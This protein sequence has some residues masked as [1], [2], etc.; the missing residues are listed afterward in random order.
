MSA[1]GPTDPTRPVPPAGGEPAAGDPGAGE[2]TSAVRATT[3]VAEPPD[4]IPT[5]PPRSGGVSTGVAI[6]AALA[7]GLLGLVIGF[8]IFNGDGDDT[9][10]DATAALD[11]GTPDEPID[12]EPDEAGPAG[13]GT[14]DDTAGDDDGV[15]ADLEAER[16]GLEAE[17]DELAQQVQDLEGQVDDLQ[18][19]LDEVTD[20]RDELQQQLDDAGEAPETVPAP[21]VVDSSVGQANDI[22]EENGWTLVRRQAQNAPADAAPGTV[23]AQ[24]PAPD[25]PMTDG[26]VLVVDVVPESTGGG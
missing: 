24:V 2:P 14:T 11:D 21:D 26:S 13:D 10:S 8:L 4:R 20:E 17:R 25:T 5:E 1:Q 3:E 6:A 18:T 19:E 23:V 15:I 12:E 9:S 22:A 16:D 7:V